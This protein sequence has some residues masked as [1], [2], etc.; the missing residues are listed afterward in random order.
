[1]W[2]WLRDSR[3]K[4]IAILL[5]VWLTALT[6]D[7]R[8]IFLFYPVAAVALVVLF[9]FLTALIRYKIQYFSLSSIVTGLLIGLVL[10]P[11]GFWQLVLA[12]FVAALSKHL[13]KIAPH[14][15]IFNPAVLGIV[16][17]VFIFNEPVAWWSVAWGWPP[18]II[19]AAGMCLVL[20]QIR[21][22][23]MPLTFLVAYYLINLLS[24]DPTAS[25][26]LTFDGTVFLFAF[27]MLPEPLT[28]LGR[29]NW[30]FAW[31]ILVGLL[32]YLQNVFRLFLADPLLVGL[33]FTNLI[34]F[35]LVR[36]V[37]FKFSLGNASR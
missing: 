29:K 32:I 36:R 3:G 25:W 9:D 15:H 7:F 33:L 19:I 26:R 4:V 6:Y 5:A 1:M 2:H 23:F 13:L 17:A 10:A 37:E 18:I 31:G 12:T 22:F 34:G 14:R 35:I 24:S 16:S 8:W 28:S 20:W 11:Y 27:V 30:Q 21:R